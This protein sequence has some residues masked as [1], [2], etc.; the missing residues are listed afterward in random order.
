MRIPQVYQ[1]KR[2]RIEI[3]PLIDIIFF[4]LATF[5]MVSLSMVKNQGIT[6]N[7]PVATTS[8]PIDRVVAKTVTVTK[9]GDIFLD[10]ERMGIGEVSNRLRQLKSQN[11]DITILINGDDAADFGI[12]VNILDEVRNL[13]ISKVSIQ[14]KKAEAK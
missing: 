13:G 1:R 3:V 4:L 6:I 7:L 10:K 14:T 11:K 12:V 5:V 8:Q 9:N 2:A